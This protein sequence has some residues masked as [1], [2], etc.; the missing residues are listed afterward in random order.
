MDNLPF[1]SGE[2]C[3]RQRSGH[4]HELQVDTQV[5]T[6]RAPSGHRSGH[7]ATAPKW[8]REVDIKG[9][10]PSLWEA[11]GDPS[12]SF[13]FSLPEPTTGPFSGPHAERLRRTTEYLERPR[14]RR[15][16][17]EMIS[18]S[19]CVTMTTRVTRLCISSADRPANETYGAVHPCSATP[20]SLSSRPSW[21]QGRRVQT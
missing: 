12:Q 3:P 21:Q 18:L 16:R 1:H 5:D 4:A 14:A 15:G 13:A 6:L 9:P 11:P 7:D 20:W 17:T 10:P 2:C 8:T 19:A